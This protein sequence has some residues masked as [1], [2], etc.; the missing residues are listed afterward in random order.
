M[1]ADKIRRAHSRF[2]EGVLE[3]FHTIA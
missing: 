2:V 1:D 3:E